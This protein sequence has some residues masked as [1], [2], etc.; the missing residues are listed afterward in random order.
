[1]R[2]FDSHESVYGLMF[3]LFLCKI[4]YR[5]VRDSVRQQRRSNETFDSVAP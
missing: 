2:Q 4:I 5:L 1:M 3:V